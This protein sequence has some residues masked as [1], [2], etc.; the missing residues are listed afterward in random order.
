MDVAIFDARVDS[1]KEYGAFVEI[2]GGVSGLLHV[3]EISDERVQNVADF[4]T[5]G[6]MI[7]VK[8]VEIDKMGRLKL[9]AKAVQS[10][11]KKEA[12]KA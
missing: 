7:K 2:G 8:V 1:I 10:L 5:E 3:S 12:P 11:K 4:I 6:E 9:S